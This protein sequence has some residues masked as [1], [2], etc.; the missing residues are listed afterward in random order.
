M[1]QWERP[2]ARIR[3]GAGVL[4]G[5]DGRDWVHLLHVSVTGD[6]IGQVGKIG[7]SYLTPDTFLKLFIVLKIQF[8]ICPSF[9]TRA[10]ASSLNL[11]LQV[12]GLGPLCC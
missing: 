12:G 9:D 2:K 8:L 3:S 5:E 4:V 1:R 10:K 11:S 6:F 7:K